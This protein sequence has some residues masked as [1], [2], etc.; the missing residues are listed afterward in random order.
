TLL[1]GDL[2]NQPDFDG[3][4]AIIIDGAYGGQARDI[5]GITTAGVVTPA[6]NFGGVILA[7]TTFAILPIRTTPAEVAALTALVVA[8]AADVEE[9]ID[10]VA[11][12][13]ESLI[14][15]WQDLLIDPNIWTVT[16][17]AT[18]A[19]WAPAVA[20]AFIECLTTPNASE[21]ARLIGDHLWQLH[22]IT[23]N[24]NLIVKKTIMEWTMSIGVLA[25]IDN[26]HTFFGWIPGVG[27]TRNNDNII[28]FC[29]LGDVLATLTDLGSAETE[30]TTFLEDLTLLHKFRIEVYEG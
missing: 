29:L 8:L 1:C 26:A 3:N 6:S 15:T 22:S 17:P 11:E 10:I 2:V 19:A 4:H 5:N 14:E 25:N 13:S 24:L 23:P 9:G 16:N 28:G 7:G 27:N 20:G 21:N 12:P 30:N 18:G